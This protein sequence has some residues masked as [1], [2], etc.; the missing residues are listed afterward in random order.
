MYYL[1]VH[2]KSSIRGCAM[3]VV[4]ELINSTRQK[5]KTAMEKKDAEFIRN[6]AVR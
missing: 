6:L 5:I 1:F 2:A 3:I 4:G